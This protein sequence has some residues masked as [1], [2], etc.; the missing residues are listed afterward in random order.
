MHRPS[1]RTA[2]WIVVLVA[3]AALA[4]CGSD[5]PA[6]SSDDDASTPAADT[7][8]PL[9]DPTQP[10]TPSATTNE[11]STLTGAEICERLT[12]DSVAADLGLDVTASEPDDRSTPQCAYL[13]DAG[14]GFASNLTVAAMRPS[15]VGGASGDAAFEFVV[16]INRQVAGDDA[17]EQTINAGDNAIRL[18]GQSLHLGVVQVGDNVYTLTI[19]ADDTEPDAVDQLITTMATTLP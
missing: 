17:E 11:V 10:V 14:S 16:G 9:A 3:T 8:D 19:G 7:S 4:A 13:Y 6:T 1:S 12:V 15:D 2:R 18:S 5:D